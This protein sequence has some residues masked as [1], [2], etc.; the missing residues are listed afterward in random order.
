METLKETDPQAYHRL[1]S[2]LRRNP[3]AIFQDPSLLSD[4]F[5]VPSAVVVE[6]LD[7]VRDRVSRRVV[8]GSQDPQPL[9]QLVTGLMDKAIVPASKSIRKGWQATTSSPAW[10]VGISTF[11]ASGL[12]FLLSET[13]LGRAGARAASLNSDLASTIIFLSAVT[14]QFLCYFRH[15]MARH[16]VYGGL[17]NWVITSTLAIV[18]VWFS[19]Q[20]RLNGLQT[21]YLNLAIVFGLLFVNALY[22]GLGVVVAVI[23]A[24]SI[25]RRADAKRDRLSRQELLQRMFEIEER[26]RQGPS[27]PVEDVGLLNN[28]VVQRLARHPMASSIALGLA[29]GSIQV[30]TI[31]T[32]TILDAGR[33]SGAGYEIAAQVLWLVISLAWIFCEGILGFVNRSFARSFL[34]CLLFAAAFALPQAIPFGGYGPRHL[35]AYFPTFYVATFF[36]VL[37][38]AA[39]SSLGAKVEEKATRA[40]GLRKNDPAALLAELLDIQFRLTPETQTVCVLVVDVARSAEMK[41]AADPFVVEYSFREYQNFVADICDRYRGTVHSTAGDGA[42]VAFP[43]CPEA[44]GA[45]KRIQ[46]EVDEFNREV[47]RLRAPFRL[48][49]GLHRGQVQGDI[50]KVQFTEVIDIAAHVQAVAP[51]GGIAMTDAVAQEL[52]DEPMVQLRDKVDGQTVWLVLNPTIDQ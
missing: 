16:A 12:I 34:A 13:G 27:G 48:R 38:I 52:G 6:V 24:Y 23:G 21:L 28:S 35:L 31:G 11:A 25:M 42:V 20:E 30:A 17:L 47:N 8:E 39:I 44:F 26:L 7:S 51:V 45:A 33:K 14:L 19:G 1:A 41:T 37:V 9:A 36:L 2:F 3:D 15:G 10:F 18:S 22:A 32:L 43:S 49:I 5:G 40:R 29:L 4:R 46:T 50:G